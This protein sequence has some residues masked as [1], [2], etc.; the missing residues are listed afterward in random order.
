MCMEGGVLTSTSDMLKH[1]ESAGV[2]YSQGIQAPLYKGKAL[3]RSR[4][5]SGQSTMVRY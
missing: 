5:E 2:V 1:A 4:N 3:G